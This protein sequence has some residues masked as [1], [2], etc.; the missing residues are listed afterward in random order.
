[1]EEL[2]P[3]NPTEGMNSP[4][5]LVTKKGARGTSSTSVVVIKISVKR[6]LSL[7]KGH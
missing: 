5:V 7:F 6:F 4:R 3:V 2:E 1:M